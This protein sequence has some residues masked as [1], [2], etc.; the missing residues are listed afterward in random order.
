MR[1]LYAL[2][3]ATLAASL[4]ALPVRAADEPAAPADSG[5]DSEAAKAEVDY[6]KELVEANLP[7]IAADVIAAAKKRWPDL[8]PKLKVMELQGELR[9]GHFDAVQK[10]VDEIKDKKSGEYWALRLA[11]AD[12]YYARDNMPECRKIYKE[13]FAAVKDP[14]PGLKQFYVEAGYKWSQMLIMQKKFEEAIP[15]YRGILKQ[16]IEENAWCTIATDD[17]ELLIRL[18]TA[19]D[20]APAKR[21]AYLKEADGIADKLLWKNEMPQVFGRAISLKAH[22]HMLRGNIDKAQELVNEYMPQLTDIHNALVEQ[23]PDGKLGYVR[24]SPM[25]QCRYL[26]AKMLWEA[27]KEEA[28]KPDAAKAKLSDLILGVKVNGRRNGAGAFGHAINVFVKFPESSWATAAGEL[29]DEINKFVVEKFG[30]DLKKAANVSPDQMKK[31]RQMQFLNAYDSYRNAEWENAIRGYGDILKQYPEVE[32]SVGS[33]ANLAESYLNLWKAAKAGPD[34]DAL[35]LDTSAVEGYLAE[36]FSGK[37][38]F[39][40]AAGDQVLRLA[41]KER[42]LGAIPRSFELFDTYFRCYPGHYQASQMAMSLGGQAWKAEDWERAAFYYGIVANTYTNSAYY[43]ASLQM[44]S[45]ASGKMGDAEAEIDWLRKFAAASKRPVDKV[46]A[47][48][49]LAV[50]QQQRGFA[51]FKAAETN[52]ATAADLKKQGAINVIKATKDFSSVAEAAGKYLESKGLSKE[53]RARLK[54]NQ[55]TAYCLTGDSFQRLTFPEKNIPA[56]R[57]RAVAAFEDYLKVSPKGKL[58]PSV[59]VKIGTIY[60]AEKDM[61]K[62]KET[63]ARLKK[64]FPDSEE[65]KNSTP[66]L[67]KTLIDMGLKSEAVEQ[68]SEMLRTSGNY[69][70]QQFLSAGDALVDARAW[71]PSRAAYAKA[72]ELA[73][74]AEVVQTN[75]LGRAQIGRAKSFFREGRLAEAHEVLDA[76][77][78]DEMF[79]KSFLI[80]DAY[81]MLIEVA[82]EEGRTE[83]DDNLRR[84]YFNQAVGAI[85]KVRG[86]RKEKAQQDALDLMSGDVLVRKMDAEESMGLKEQARETCA[87]AVVT[88]Q[89]FV[90]ANAPDA[91]HPADKMTP[92]QLAN[93]ERCYGTVLPLMAKL[94]KDQKE[95]I[96]EYGATYKELF[97]SGRHATAVQ[98]AINQANAE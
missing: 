46:A 72:A 45:M 25:P 54:R 29:V 62:A 89:A 85:K 55:E 38:A 42:E 18:A 22:I 95:K 92:E 75:N 41:A 68:Y 78:A 70:A 71:E 56:F 37:R 6:I 73:K 28:K 16:K 14:P 88:F 39:F 77:T 63:F 84:K 74:S 58:A 86:Y 27:V 90:M 98:N 19:P 26:L 94:G 48:L 24:M 11:M 82:S 69:T 93:L 36:R 4:L 2:S 17:A 43:A 44:L 35:R 66:R 81:D 5:A 64:D 80:V 67:A 31:V 53:D 15:V 51:L 60:T 40:K 23:D 49:S 1:P 32:E 87:R 3:A 83:K 97:P 65:A 20:A 33:V 96:L 12:A 10:V 8:G 7:D 50:K 9:L 76:F 13:F 30:K 91:E 79:A 57:K 34:R 59:L 47:H 52:E 61:D 21:D